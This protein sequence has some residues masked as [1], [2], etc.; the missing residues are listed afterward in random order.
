MSLR[1]HDTSTDQANFRWILRNNS[2]TI[3]QWGHTAKVMTSSVSTNNSTRS[4]SLRNPQRLWEN[5]ECWRP[6][7]DIKICSFLLRRDITKVG[8]SWRRHTWAGNE[9]VSNAANENLMTI[10]ACTLRVLE[11]PHLDLGASSLQ[12][13]KRRGVEVGSSSAV[14]YVY[15]YAATCQIAKCYGIDPLSHGKS[16]RYQSGTCL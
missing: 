3:F 7:P 5:F 16:R 12:R 14:L 4:Y 10:H 2:P 9:C 8:R 6:E 1:Y 15:G 11:N 13:I